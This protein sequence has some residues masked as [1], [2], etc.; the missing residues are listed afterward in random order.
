VKLVDA[1]VVRAAIPGVADMHRLG[2][3]I[4]TLVVMPEKLWMMVSLQAV[5][6]DAGGSSFQI[7]P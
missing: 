6:P 3:G 5:F 7:V 1:S 2:D 4:L